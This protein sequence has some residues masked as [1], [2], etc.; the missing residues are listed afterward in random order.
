M[1]HSATL[2]IDFTTVDAGNVTANVTFFD[3]D[4][5]LQ[6]RLQNTSEYKQAYN[7]EQHTH[8]KRLVDYDDE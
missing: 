5:A 4:A 2:Q 1:P 8:R 3:M 7:G 6:M